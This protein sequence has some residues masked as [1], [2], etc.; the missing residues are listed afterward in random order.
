GGQ[1][2]G[3]TRN[4][5]GHLSS[6][7]RAFDPHIAGRSDAHS[8]KWLE[9][10]R[11]LHDAQVAVVHGSQRLFSGPPYEGHARRFAAVDVCR[12]REATEVERILD[13]RFEAIGHQAWLQG[14]LAKG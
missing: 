11:T 4:G 5:P 12:G 3:I 6:T 7:L 10:L 13:E 8:L 2:V 1:L 9:Q 14:V